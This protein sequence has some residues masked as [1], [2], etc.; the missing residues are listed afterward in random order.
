M[1]SA[2]NSALTENDGKDGEKAV[3][4]TFETL[5]EKYR[6]ISNEINELQER[7]KKART[8]MEYLK[9]QNHKNED[10]DLDSY[11]AAIENSADCSKVEMGKLTNQLFELKSTSKKLEKLIE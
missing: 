9:N 8:S 2:K 11:M 6:N 5:T 3:P 7:I 4:E 10:E 1:Q